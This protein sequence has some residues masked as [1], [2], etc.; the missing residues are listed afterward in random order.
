MPHLLATISGH[1]YGHLAQSAPV[2]NA[3]RERLPELALTIRSDLPREV[4]ARRIHGPFAHQAVG[5]DFGMVMHNALQVDVAAS[6]AR[7]RQLHADW[8][9]RVAAVASELQVVVPDLVFADVP[10]LTLAAAAQCGI[11]AVAMCCLNWLDI[12]RHY[13]AALPEA[14]GVMAQMHAAYNSAQVFLRTEPAM[15]MSALD[16]ISTIGPVAYVG[17]N[18]RSE[19]DHRFGLSVQD[20]LVLVGMGGIAHRLPMEQWPEFPGVRFV[21]QA[22]WQVQR[23][24]AIVLEDTGMIFSDVLASVDAIITK[25]GYGTFV[26]AAA[27][28]V[29]L[30]YVA[31]DDWP[32]EPYLVQWLRQY[33][34]CVELP[35]QSMAQGDISQELYAALAAGRAPSIVPHGIAAAVNV[36]AELLQ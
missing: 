2:L 31:R 18:R 22:D 13:C 1:G 35:S 24:D 34:P 23:P 14:D 11:P 15:P 33:N 9:G 3:L 6:A 19:L 25:P 5:D 8:P 26:E 29:P 28:G 12:Y 21:V 17:R 30:L 7:Y 32:E 16:N 20:R 27:A 4:L 36:L 10:Y